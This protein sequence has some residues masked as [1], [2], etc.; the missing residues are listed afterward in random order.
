MHTT[1]WW[2]TFFSGIALDFWRAAVPP[3]QTRTEADYLQR[4]LKA[5]DKGKIL[6]VP[7]GTGRLTLELASRGYRTTGVDIA[8]SYVGAAQAEAQQRQLPA[9]FQHRDMRELP[10]ESEFD[11]AFCYGNSFGYMADEDNAR[12]LKTV[13]RCLKPGAWFALDTGFIAECLFPAFVERRWFKFGDIYF[14]SQAKYDLAR[15]RIQTEYTFMRDGTIE[16]KP[17]SSRVH[18]CR[19]L[20][21][22]LGQAG[23]TEIQTAGGFAGEEAKFGGPR[24]LFTAKRA[25]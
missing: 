9:E 23:F 12:F 19:E 1:D 18:T 5:P 3:E 25:N 24:I 4:V 17:T 7:C 15:S 13:C 10:W 6:D 21:E 20:T 2:Q 11:A 16:V 22:L 8:E 14:M